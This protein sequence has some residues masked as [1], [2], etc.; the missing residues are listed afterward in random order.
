MF[1]ILKIIKENKYLI[2]TWLKF[3]IESNYIDAK[4]GLFWL[5][6]E[7]ILQ[8]LIYTLIFSVLFN[9]PPRGGV[10]FIIF[11]LS[12]ITIWQFINGNLMQAG[13]MMVRYSRLQFNVKVS[14]EALVIIEL[15]EKLVDLAINLFILVIISSFLGYYPTITYIYF[16]VVLLFIILTTLGGMFF[17]GSLGV[18]IRDIPNITSM[19]MRL[20]FFLSGVIITPDMLPESYRGYLYLNPILQMIEATRDLLIYSQIPSLRTFLYMG[21]FAILIFF[22]GYSYFKKHQGIFVDYQ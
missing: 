21:A 18:F 16:P 17:L 15:L 5:I 6:L 7:P 1:S 12:G 20:L 10:P 11:Y 4:L 2:S 22:F 13:P 8:T 19:I 14:S 3:N 9:R